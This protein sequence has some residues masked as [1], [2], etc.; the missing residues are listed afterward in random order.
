MS[1]LSVCPALFELAEDEC[2]KSFEYVMTFLY[3]F[4]KLFGYIKTMAE[5]DFNFVTG[6]PKSQLTGL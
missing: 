6:A 5:Y 2:L 3:S 4:F 1:Y